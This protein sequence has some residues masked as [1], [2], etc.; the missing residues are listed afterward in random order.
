MTV[1]RRSVLLG[2][3]A[4]VA[5]RVGLLAPPVS[6][7]QDLAALDLTAL[8]LTAYRGKVVYLDFWASWCVPCRQS[9]PFME[10]LQRE[11]GPE[12]LVVI[13]VNVDTERSLAAGFLAA[14]PVGFKIVYDPAGKLAEQWQLEGMP[15]TILIRRNGEGAPPHDGL[16]RVDQ[17][18]L[19]T[20][21][22]RLLA[23]ENP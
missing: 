3:S 11:H 7:H 9:F 4:A 17:T 15:T 19:Q 21:V 10:A 23:V 8:D 22:F 1:D 13:A 18:T 16:R 14:T 6:A 20:T 2:L 5:L 12:G